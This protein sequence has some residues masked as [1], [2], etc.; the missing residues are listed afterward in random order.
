MTI[1]QPT[2]VD[3]PNVTPLSEWRVRLAGVVATC[4]EAAS[5]V[6][7]GV[8]HLA[9]VNAQTDKALAEQLIAQ[10]QAQADGA[11]N[12]AAASDQLARLGLPNQ[13]YS[14]Q[15][16]SQNDWRPIVN[17]ALVA[18]KP[19][20]F[21]LSNAT[22]LRD[23]YTGAYFDR[24]VFGHAIV[25]VG[26]DATGYIVAD[27]NTATG[28]YQ[29]Y[30]AQNLTAAGASS[31]VVPVDPPNAL[32]AEGADATYAGFLPLALALND[33]QTFPPFDVTNP[34][35]A[36]IGDF[37]AFASRGLFVVIGLVIFLAAL[38]WLVR[39]VVM[40]SAEVGAQAAQIAA[41]AA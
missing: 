17:A 29:H 2:G 23:T 16:F 27:P 41:L 33:A 38:W 26:R 40:R 15:W 20:L 8:Y 12:W 10:G 21:G 35:A 1:T 39:P 31:M 37:E 18:H 30:T 32:F 28:G 25:I 7:L 36:V 14:P 34:V 9:P 13:A 22:A 24:G 11:T 5:T 4:V 3:V 19:V 6:L